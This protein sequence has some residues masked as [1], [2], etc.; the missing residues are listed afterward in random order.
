MPDDLLTNIR[1]AKG[2]VDKSLSVLGYIVDH[3]KDDYLMKG[4]DAAEQAAE[5]LSREV[6]VIRMNLLIATGQI[7]SVR[8]PM[9]D[10]ERTNI[11][12][13]IYADIPVIEREEK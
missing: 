9:H 7:D 4:L 6:E 10:P 13:G 12:E 5:D 8:G 1:I 2:I 3:Q 11:A